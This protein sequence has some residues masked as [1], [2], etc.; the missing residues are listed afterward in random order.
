[1]RSEVTKKL[2]TVDEYYRMAEAGVLDPDARLELVEGEIL[3]MSP[4][5]VR[6]VSCVNRATALFARKFEGKAVV[7]IQNPVFD[8]IPSWSI[9][10]RAQRPT[11][12]LSPFIAGIPFRSLPFRMLFSR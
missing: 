5:G 7:S 6:H 1:M 8:T 12:H 3:E 10:I 11:P 2:F 9:A 4:V